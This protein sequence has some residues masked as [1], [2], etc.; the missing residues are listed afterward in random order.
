MGRM[1][2]LKVVAKSW[3][4]EEVGKGYRGCFIEDPIGPRFK[5]SFLC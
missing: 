3:D 1:H 2:S 5:F 4:N